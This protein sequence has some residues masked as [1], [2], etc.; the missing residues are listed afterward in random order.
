MPEGID[1]TSCGEKCC[2][3][4]ATDIESLPRFKKPP[5]VETVLGVHFRPLGKLTS[6]HQGLRWERCFRHR[7]PNLEERRPV[8]EAR[9]R[10]G[11]K[12]LADTPA[13][14]WQ[15]MDRPGGGVQFEWEGGDRREFSSFAR[16]SLA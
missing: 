9:E 15:V 13:V 12:R 8:E 4:M 2:I 10:F 3:E 14:R 5:V 16:M 1:R 11:D 7:F 6:A